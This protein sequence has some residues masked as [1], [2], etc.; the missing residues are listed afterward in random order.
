MAK[1]L[2][3]TELAT[4]WPISKVWASF[5]ARD[6]DSLAKFVKQRYEERFFQPIRILRAA[7]GQGTGF[8][9][10]IMSLCSLLIESLQSYRYGLPTTYESEYQYLAV[11]NPPPEA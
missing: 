7:P 11:F 4:G 10:A 5:N 8:G 2:N 3:E 6:K 9:F 1:K